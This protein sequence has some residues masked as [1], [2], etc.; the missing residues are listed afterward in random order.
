MSG[1]REASHAG[2]WYSAHSQTLSAQL[3]QWLDTVP[4]ISTCTGPISSKAG[5]IAAAQASF[6]TPGARVVIAPHAGYSYSGSAAAW[7]Y[8]AAD[9]DNAKRVFILGPSHHYY[10][11]K[12]ALSRFATYSTPFGELKLDLSTIAS[13]RATGNFEDMSLAA[14]EDE[15]SIEMHLPYVHKM[16]VRTFSDYA[17]IPPIVPVLVGS[18]SQSGERQ[19]GSLL[20]PYLADPANVFVVSSDFAHWGARFRYTYYEPSV[21]NTGRELLLDADQT[22]QAPRGISLPHS[23]TTFTGGKLTEHEM[24][25]VSSLS[26]VPKDPP[27]HQSIAQVDMR[28][29]AACETGSVDKFWRVLE[30]TGNTVCGRHPIGVVMA[31]LEE[32]YRAHQ[33]KE[34]L[35]AGAAAGQSKNA[36]LLES[37]WKGRFRFVRY[38]RSSDCH[39]Y[40]KDSS[41]SYASAYAVI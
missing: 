41:V 2:S 8:R 25:T 22:D 11:P 4:N 29:M 15:H 14:D 38:E 35:P 24:N 16:L 1:S 37:G 7:A 6:P 9:W 33:L 40:K 26:T 27:I 36:A 28:C 39:N 32:L 19:Y 20:A 18:T 34:N 10:T 13:L 23:S 12:C 31:G 30:R 21:L 3:D 17:R 5:S